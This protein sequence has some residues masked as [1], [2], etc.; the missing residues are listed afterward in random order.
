MQTPVAKARM[1]TCQFAQPFLNQAVISS[2]SIPAE[3]IAGADFSAS[4]NFL[5]RCVLSRDL[6]KTHYLENGFIVSKRQESVGRRR[7]GTFSEAN[8]VSAQALSQ[9]LPLRF[10]GGHRK[11]GS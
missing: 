4:T 7:A 8:S 2:A 3:A 10:L 6:D 1:L 5:F 9:Q 11:T